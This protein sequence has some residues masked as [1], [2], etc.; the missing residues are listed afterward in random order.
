MTTERPRNKEVKT[1]TKINYVAR[2]NLTKCSATSAFIKTML[3]KEHATIC[4]VGDGEDMRWNFMT[5]L[6]FVQF[7]H[8][9]S[10]DWQA[11]VRVDDHTEQPRVRLQTIAQHTPAQHTKYA[12]I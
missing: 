8:F 9:F 2:I 4:S 7:D 12:Q 1:K 11:L 3:T 10:V 6:A 5:L